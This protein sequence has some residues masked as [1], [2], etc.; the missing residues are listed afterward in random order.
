MATS[1]FF[2]ELAAFVILVA[3]FLIRYFCMKDEVS[4]TDLRDG[5]NVMRNE[6]AAI[7]SDVQKVNGKLVEIEGRQRY[8]GEQIRDQHIEILKTSHFVESSSE[9][10]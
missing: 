1:D 10:E 7:R 2:F 3:T 4:L 9:E 8:I 5:Q 6:Q